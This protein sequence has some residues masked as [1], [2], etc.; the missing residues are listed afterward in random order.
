MCQRLP[1]LRE[2]LG[3]YA[4]QFDAALLSAADARTVLGHAT[5][6]EH[7]A[8]T[9]KALA[10][11]RIADTGAEAGLRSPAHEVAQA[12]GTSIGAARRSLDIGRRLGRQPEVAAAARRGE[13][14]PSQLSAITG[15]ADADPAAASRL[16]GRAR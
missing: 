14:S 6:I 10:A 4:A 16:L 7:L 11:A 15:A 9:I 1:E 13:L 3:C 8:A 5:A 12:T 2:G